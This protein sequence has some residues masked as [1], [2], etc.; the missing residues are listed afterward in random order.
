MLR[1]LLEA[2]HVTRG[3]V[4]LQ[5]SDHHLQGLQGGPGEAA[6]QGA[7][8]ARDPL[9]PGGVEVQGLRLA[10]DPRGNQVELGVGTLPGPPAAQVSL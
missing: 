10:R 6:L 3:Q 8:L 7:I 1:T 2:P 9:R 5:H 4:E